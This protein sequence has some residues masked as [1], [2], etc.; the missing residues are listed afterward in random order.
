MYIYIGKDGHFKA[1]LAA[2]NI[3]YDMLKKEAALSDDP[4]SYSISK[5]FKYKRIIGKT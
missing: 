2:G 3:L 5:D 1:A 4:E